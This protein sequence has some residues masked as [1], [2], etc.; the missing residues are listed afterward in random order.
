MSTRLKSPA[1]LA[2]RA[3]CGLTDV[4]FDDLGPVGR[5]RILADMQVVLRA[6]VGSCDEPHDLPRLDREAPETIYLQVDIDADATARDV[7]FPHAVDGVTWSD[8]PIG[9]LEVR[10]IRADFCAGQND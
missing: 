5:A 7:P 10:Y 2:A 6:A 3:F 4:A 8:E 1:E 9:G